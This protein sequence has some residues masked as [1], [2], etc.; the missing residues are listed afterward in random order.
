LAKGAATVEY[1][2]GGAVAKDDRAGQCIEIS[3]F[4]GGAVLQQAHDAMRVMADEVGFHQMAG[5]DISVIW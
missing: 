3:L 5:H 2:T 4:D 1:S